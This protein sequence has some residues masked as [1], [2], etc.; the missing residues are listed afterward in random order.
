MILYY[1]YSGCY[2][3]CSRSIGEGRRWSWNPFELKIK[4]DF[5]QKF[6]LLVFFGVFF[7]SSEGL[8]NVESFQHCCLCCVCPLDKMRLF[9]SLTANPTVRVPKLQ[10]LFKPTFSFLNLK[11]IL[12]GGRN[13]NV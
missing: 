12:P 2:I 8:N 10:M 6:L 9:I 7:V 11:I 13:V 3:R 1:Y 5:F 4:V